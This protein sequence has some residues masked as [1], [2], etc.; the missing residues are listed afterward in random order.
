MK[1][2]NCE[3]GTPEWFEA[4]L[5]K[6]SGTRLAS[7]IGN[8]LKQ[9]ALINELI[10][11]RLT[12]NRKEITQSKAMALG[13]EAEEHA[14]EEYELETGV[15][16]EAVG[17]CINDKFDWLANSPDRLIKIDGKY[18]K[19]VEVKCPN[20]DTLVKYI[21]AN[22]IP[23]EYDAQVMSYF[24]VNDDLQELDFVAYDPRI[25]TEQ[26]RLWIKNIKREELPLEETRKEVIRF[27]VKW[28]TA[29]KNLNLE[30]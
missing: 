16:T 4:K 18:S 13:V 17:L 10:A 30:L 6:I 9:E 7:A 27:Y 28:Q 8:Q 29:L 25:Q 2:I 20:T 5:E 3:Q 14:I 12:G 23:P 15:I 21:R 26:Y 1:I 22:E 11:E 19:A 24:L